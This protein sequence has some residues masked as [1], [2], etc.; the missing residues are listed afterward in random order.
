[1]TRF[2]SQD[3]V[4]AAATQIVKTAESSVD[5][6]GAWIT[7]SALRILLQSIRSKIETGQLQLRIVCRLHGL[8]D[9]DITDLGAIK[10][11]EQ[12]GAQV[13]FSRR[14][15]AKMVLVDRK[16]GIVSSSNL[17]STA[18]YVYNPTGVEWTNFEAGVVLEPQDA[19]LVAD[20]TAF[21]ERIW[22]DASPIDQRAVGVVIG[23]PTTSRLEV[24]MVRPVKRSQYVVAECDSGPLLGKIEE[25][26]TINVSFPGLERAAG[27]Q[28]STGFN[29]E[30]LPDLRALF[31]GESKEEGFLKLTTFFDPA[32]AFNVASVRVL[33]QRVE[34]RLKM[35]LVPTAPGA[36]V[37]QP[38]DDWLLSLQGQGEIQIGR[39][40]NHETVPVSLRAEELLR[41]HCAVYGMT[42]A[43]KSNG[44]KVLLRSLLT[45]LKKEL[46]EAG[47]D[48]RVIVI[49]THGEYAVSAANLDPDTRIVDVLVPDAIDLLDE[50]SVR[51]GL[52]LARSDAALKERIWALKEQLEADGTVATCAQIID[53]LRPGVTRGS[54]TERLIRTFD[55]APERVA[56]APQ[57]ETIDAASGNPEDFASPGLYILN[58][59]KVHD[60][61]TRSVAVGHVIDYVF[62]R[63]KDS[64][65][66]FNSLLVIDEVQNF[67]PESGL[68]PVRASLDA[69]LRVAR[70][71]R[72][73]GVGLVISSQR[74]ANV[75]TGLRS[76]CNTHLIFRLV[77]NN[78]LGAIADTVEAADRTL[79]T[80]MLPQLDIG[81]CFARGTAI[82]SPFFVEVPLFTRP[83]V[84]GSGDSGDEVL[85]GP[86]SLGPL[87]GSDRIPAG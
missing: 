45:W 42:G 13:R 21:F 4:A 11:F 30:P 67:A 77:N 27:S 56:I 28:N 29:R 52:N 7:G 40:L 70:E 34:G 68:D 48:L 32:A 16:H 18:G 25:I 53:A 9:L 73:F 78:D 84:V 6:T 80:S 46:A 60:A 23:E 31:T 62:E 50:G 19:E 8:T 58:L 14:L 76:Q 63:A 61:T 12:F 64:D 38:T 69:I 75:N 35:A 83:P 85:I 5:I 26:R 39:A 3:S 81:T 44:L 86:T 33:N 41:R 24:V 15:H 51:Q 47:R 55:R 65:G 79:V 57:P 87:D 22:E 36:I 71:G 66:M 43:G 49:D 59:S 37:Q 2:I 1:M 17:T 10:E 82:D 74:P 72:K 20:A 54:T